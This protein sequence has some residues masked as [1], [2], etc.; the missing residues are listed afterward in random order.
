MSLRA[1]VWEVGF[2]WNVFE[3]EF[4]QHFSNVVARWAIA[5]AYKIYSNANGILNKDGFCHKTDG[6]KI[7]RTF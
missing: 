4:G 1:R 7:E 3:S 2:S 6:L 5:M